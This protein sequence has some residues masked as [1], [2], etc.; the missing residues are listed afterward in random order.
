MKLS[1]L[2]VIFRAK[3]RDLVV[4]Y[5]CSSVEFQVFINEAEREAC[6][7]MNLIFD[8]TTTEV[9][10]IAVAEGDQ[11]KDLHSSVW[12]VMTAYLVDSNG[13]HIKLTNVDQV[14]LDRVSPGWREIEK[15]PER[16]IIEESTITLDS[17]ADAAYTLKL[18]VYRLPITDMA[19]PASAPEIAAAHHEKLLDWVK[20]NYYEIPIEGVFSPELTSIHEQR[21]EDHFGVSKTADSRRRSWANRPQHNKLW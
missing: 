17:K 12:E 10:E 13:D 20:K 8:K 9:C 14:E 21:F 15:Q 6:R 7:R 19:T 18:E 16:Y 5:N 4:P 11:V 3:V 1:E 2:E